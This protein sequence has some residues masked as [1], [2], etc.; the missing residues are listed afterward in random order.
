MK[1][2]DH[3]L[4]LVVLVV[5]FFGLS[6]FTKNIF[7]VIFFILAWLAFKVYGLYIMA[8]YVNQVEDSKDSQK[9]E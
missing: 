2:N 7:F 9:Q 3:T 6:Y 8:T 1:K 5:V 4:L